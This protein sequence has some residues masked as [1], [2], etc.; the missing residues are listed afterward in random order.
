MFWI[1][2]LGFLL[3][4]PLAVELGFR[5]Y[6]R[7]A[8]PHEGDDG[9]AAQLAGSA[10]A[11][12]GLLVGFTFAMAADRYETRRG[13]VVEEANAISTVYLRDRMFA[14]PQGPALGKL[15]LQYARERQSFFDA[16]DEAAAL[17]ASS[18]RAL[19]L[20]DQIWGLTRTAL[21][22]P[23]AAALTTASL[24]ATN[25]MFDLAS[26]RDA[27]REARVPAPVIWSVAACAF[28]AALLSG[29]ALASGGRRH[30]LAST[31]LFLLVGV[32]MVVIL[33]IDLPRGGLIRAS[34][35]PLA[36][37]VAYL[38]HE[39]AAMPN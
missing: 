12:L 38:V 16:G 6:A 25:A 8:E 15:V 36:N 20:Q 34:Q 26:S 10:L 7:L 28:G 32:A 35:S 24:N 22:A 1:E 17:E 3:G 9:G 5:A 33:D 18:R 14:A 31:A 29:Y 27:A 11:L 30:R 13:L 4:L 21:K 19:V 2:A 39:E 37:V 23:E